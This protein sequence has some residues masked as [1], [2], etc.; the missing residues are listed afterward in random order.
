MF[1]SSEE[2]Q[3]LSQDNQSPGRDSNP[4]ISNYETGVQATHKFCPFLRCPVTFHLHAN[5]AG[6]VSEEILSEMLLVVAE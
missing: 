5:E 1:I 3:N 6:R 4:G 2:N